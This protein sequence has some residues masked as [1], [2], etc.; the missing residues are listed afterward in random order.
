MTSFRR[1]NVIAG[2][3]WK[4]LKAVWNAASGMF[5]GCAQSQG[6]MH[7]PELRSDLRPCSFCGVR[8]HQVCVQH[9]AHD[10]KPSPQQRPCRSW[11]A[12]RLRCMRA[13]VR[14]RNNTCIAVFDAV[15]ALSAV[16][17]TSLD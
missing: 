9:A 3:D 17:D 16:Q 7:A 2:A 1:L 12:P 6:G 15:N 10:G 14:L 5:S 13:G 4:C 8:R 11:L